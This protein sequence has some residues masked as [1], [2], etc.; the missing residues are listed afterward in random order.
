LLLDV[1]GVVVTWLAVGVAAW[2]LGPYMYRVFDG[3]GCS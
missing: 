1:I 2:F 3:Q